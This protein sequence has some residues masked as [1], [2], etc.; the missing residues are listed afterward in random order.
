M[1]S[2]VHSLD[3]LAVRNGELAN[4]VLSETSGISGEISSFRSLYPIDMNGDGLT[5]VSRPV[6][7][8][9]L[10][11][12][13]VSYERTDWYQYHLDGE[14]KVVLRTYHNLEDGWYLRLPED[15]MD[16][17]WVSRAGSTDENTVTFYIL[18]GTADPE[19]FLKITAITGSSRENRAVRGSRFL[20]SRQDETIYTAELLQANESWRYGVTADEVREA[21]SLIAAEW[22]AGDY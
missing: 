18:K 4:I 2:F 7:L 21:F 14:N 13:G 1:R 5:E 3:I 22:S 12:D 9:S 17:I 15:W 8:F 19:P 10:R 11:D 16:R 20:L 6:Q